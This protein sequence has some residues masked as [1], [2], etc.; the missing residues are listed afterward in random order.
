[1][2]RP[3]SPVPS[4]SLNA[5]PVILGLMCVAQGDFGVSLSL[6]VCVCVCTYIYRHTYNMHICNIALGNMHTTN[7]LP[8]QTLHKEYTKNKLENLTVLIMFIK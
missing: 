6:Y 1:M 2:H 3:Q 7:S 5:M 8:K 4:R